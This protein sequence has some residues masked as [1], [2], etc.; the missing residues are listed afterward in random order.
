[1]IHAS[2][3]EQQLQLV[4]VANSGTNGGYVNEGFPGELTMMQGI[5]LN[6]KGNWGK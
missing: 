3:N 6:E 2:V 5:V 1:M 4:N